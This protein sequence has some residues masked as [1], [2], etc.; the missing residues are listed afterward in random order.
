MRIKP[1]IPA[2]VCG[3]ALA[4]P[5]VAS[6]GV[7]YDAATGKGFVGKGDVQTAFGWNNGDLQKNAAGV[8]F[9][10]EQPATQSLSQDSTQSGTQ[11]ATE[12]M[13]Q[14][15]TCTVE[16][17]NGKNKQTHH[18]DGMRAGSRDGSRN[19]TRSGSRTGVLNGIVSDDIAY[20]ARKSNQITG[21]N[22]TGKSSSPFVPS[23]DAVW[24]DTS[25]GEMSFGDWSFGDTE[26]GGW[27]SAP[28]ENPADCLGGSPHVTDLMVTTTTGDITTGD[29]AYGDIAY[30]DITYGEAT[31][32]GPGTMSA[33]FGGLQKVIWPPVVPVA[34][35]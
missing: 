21:F 7:Q 5:S 6:A 31:A 19:G 20:D 10:Y 4:V 33:V 29:V 16:T 11:T 26:W 12:S 34:A 23:G 22:L 1:I 15:V 2:L 13:S 9:K 35:V 14:D 17:G 28:T 18:R 3:A 32:A 24:G 25:F 27:E 8:T 30:G